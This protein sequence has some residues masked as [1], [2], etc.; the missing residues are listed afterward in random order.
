M[1]RVRGWRGNP[2][3]CLH[4]PGGEADQGIADP[5][6]GCVAF[7]QRVDSALR[8]NVHFHTLWPDGVFTCN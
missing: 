3:A 1:Q 4:N 2:P 6:V 7:T 5:R 8:L